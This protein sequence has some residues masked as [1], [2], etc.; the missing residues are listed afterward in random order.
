MRQPFSQCED[1]RCLFLFHLSALVGC[2]SEE[3]VVM[4]GVIRAS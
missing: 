1:E 2:N 3:R 4:A